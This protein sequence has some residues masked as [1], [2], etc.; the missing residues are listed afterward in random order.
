[1]LKEVLQLGDLKCGLFGRIYRRGKPWKT[2]MVAQFIFAKLCQTTSLL[3]HCPLDRH[4]QSGGWAITQYVSTL[5]VKQSGD[6][7]GFFLT[8]SKWDHTTDNDPKHTSLGSLSTAE[9]LWIIKVSSLV[10]PG[11]T[12]VYP[13]ITYRR[14]SRF[15][16]SDCCPWVAEENGCMAG[17]FERPIKL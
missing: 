13:W 1:M 2:K 3:E 9:W 7:L 5:T 16:C 17:Q 8:W 12:S 6:D 11:N 10:L 14:G 15:L 4:D